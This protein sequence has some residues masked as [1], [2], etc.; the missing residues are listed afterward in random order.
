MLS[1]YCTPY[2]LPFQLWRVKNKKRIFMHYYSNC[3]S[4][5]HSFKFLF[6]I[7]PFFY[8]FTMNL[9]CLA[10]QYNANY[11][12]FIFSSTHVYALYLPIVCVGVCALSLIPAA[13]RRVME[14]KTMALSGLP[15]GQPSKMAL[16]ATCPA[17]TWP[18]MSRLLV[19]RVINS[20]MFSA[21][22]SLFCP[23]CQW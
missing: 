23:F 22:F 14:A 1:S 16:M 7:Y 12:I 19:E 13:L 11:L 2:I 4:K 21:Y 9:F 8:F 3:Y 10:I 17:Q 18:R 20:S 6:W 5:F 15:F